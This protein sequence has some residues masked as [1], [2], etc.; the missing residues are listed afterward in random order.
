MEHLGEMRRRWLES[1]PRVGYRVIEAREHLIV[2]QKKKRRARNQLRGMVR[3]AEHTDL[4]RLTPAELASFDSQAKVNA[5]LYMVAMHHER[6]LN[7]I[8]S[9]LRDEGKID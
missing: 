3:V 6:R 5:A 8:E 1:V 4:S 9:I 2:A 7:R